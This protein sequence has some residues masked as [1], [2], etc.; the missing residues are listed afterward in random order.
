MLGYKDIIRALNWEHHKDFYFE[1]LINSQRNDTLSFNYKIRLALRIFRCAFLILIC[2]KFGCHG[3]KHNMCTRTV[4][5]L[6]YFRLTIKLKFWLFLIPSFEISA[7]VH[8]IQCDCWNTVLLC[9]TINPYHLEKG[10]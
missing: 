4:N 1:L 8:L 3:I 2:L 10:T 7:T 6:L 9:K 5:G